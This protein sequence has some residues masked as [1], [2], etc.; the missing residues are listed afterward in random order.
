L[1]EAELV[2]LCTER[3]DRTDVGVPPLSAVPRSQSPGGTADPATDMQQIAPQIAQRVPA[4]RRGKD[5]MVYAAHCWAPNSTFTDPSCNCLGEPAHPK[6]G[7]RRTI[8]II[9]PSWYGRYSSCRLMLQACFRGIQCGMHPLSHASN[10]CRPGA[11]LDA[12]LLKIVVEGRLGYPVEMLSDGQLADIGPG[13]KISDVNAGIYSALARG[14]AD[15]YPEVIPADPCPMAMVVCSTQA[16]SR[17][18]IRFTG[19]AVLRGRRLRRVRP[20]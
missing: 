5:E 10:V 9:V 2:Q 4:R 12:F 20:S 18:S 3:S 14:E 7:S 19:V 13:L 17:C 15:M 6:L 1:V 16:P 8:K 11:A